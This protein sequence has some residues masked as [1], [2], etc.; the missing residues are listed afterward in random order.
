MPRM[1]Y[2]RHGF[3]LHIPPGYF[4]VAAFEFEWRYAAC[5]GTDAETSPRKSRLHLCVTDPLRNRDRIESADIATAENFDV[6]PWR[7]G[8]PV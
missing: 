4:P 8:T 1:A 6:N 2:V 7:G 5:F 3:R